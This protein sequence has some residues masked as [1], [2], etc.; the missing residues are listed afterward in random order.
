MCIKRNF[1]SE[2]ENCWSK[3]LFPISLTNATKITLIFEYPKIG[4]LYFFVFS[5]SFHRILSSVLE[6]DDL[7]EK[8]LQYV[9]LFIFAYLFLFSVLTFS[10]VLQ[11][12]MST[13]ASDA[14]SRNVLSECYSC[15]GNHY[16]F[17]LKFYLGFRRMLLRRQQ[18]FPFS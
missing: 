15:K 14:V 9:S 12:L 16:F 7:N 5:F 13:C 10:V 11:R 17:H 3:E 18:L 8:E 2:K 6:K 4:G 1:V